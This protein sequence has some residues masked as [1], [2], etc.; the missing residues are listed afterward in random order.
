MMKK[1]ARDIGVP[2]SGQQTNQKGHLGNARLGTES[3]VG[4]HHKD[5]EQW[6]PVE[7]LLFFAESNPLK[8]RKKAPC[9]RLTYLNK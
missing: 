4:H 8:S 7:D 1:I 6:P 2:I 9:N 5:L 3:E